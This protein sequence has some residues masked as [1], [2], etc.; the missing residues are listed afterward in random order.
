MHIEQF[1]INAQWK[2]TG[3]V[4]ILSHPDDEALFFGSVE[5]LC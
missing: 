1:E 4:Y 3:A 5:C 2:D